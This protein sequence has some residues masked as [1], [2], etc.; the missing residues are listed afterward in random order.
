MLQQFLSK[1]QNTAESIQFSDTIAVIERYY[2][3]QPSAFN[4]GS[5][6]NLS[7]QNEGSCKILFFALLNQLSSEQ[8]LHC[9]GHYYRDEVLAKPDA[10]NHQNIRAFMRS[11]SAGLY[12]EYPVLSLRQP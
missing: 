3:Y 8:T 1:L 9:F 4:N 5:V 7:G 12:F 2:D 11:G 6:H 10:D